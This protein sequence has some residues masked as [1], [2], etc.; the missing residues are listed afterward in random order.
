MTR[1]EE[2]KKLKLEGEELRRKAAMKLKRVK[3]HY[4][5]EED[6]YK[7]VSKSIHDNGMH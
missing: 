1:K 6:K 3:E 2:R 5:K 7:G 4:Q